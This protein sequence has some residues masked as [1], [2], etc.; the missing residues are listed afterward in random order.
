MAIGFALLAGF[1]LVEARR[2]AR[3]LIDTRLLR[4]RAVGAAS[5]VLFLAGAARCASRCRPGAP[6][7]RV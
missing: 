5:A 4:V 1:I 7:R 3:A 2:P 6:C